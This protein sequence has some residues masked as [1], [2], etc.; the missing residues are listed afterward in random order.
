ML[1]GVLLQNGYPIFNLLAKDKLEFN[2]KMIEF[3]YTKDGTNLL[4][5]LI[6]YYWAKNGEF[7]R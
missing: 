3:Y 6:E 1:N 7:G 4:E 2:K 5:F